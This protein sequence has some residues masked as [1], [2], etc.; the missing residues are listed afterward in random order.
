MYGFIHTNLRRCLGEVITLLV[1]RDPGKKDSKFIVHKE[2]LCAASPFF[3]AACKLEW[4]RVEKDIIRLPEDD[5]EVIKAFIHW[6]Y[7]NGDI[8]LPLESRDRRNPIDRPEGL[9]VKLYI[10]GDKYQMPRLRNQA[11][12]ALDRYHEANLVGFSLKVLDYA[13][14]NAAKHSALRTFLAVTAIATWDWDQFDEL[15]EKLYPEF[16]H[17]VAIHLMRSRDEGLP[18]RVRESFCE[19]YHTH[20][21]NYN[22]ADCDEQNHYGMKGWM[23]YEM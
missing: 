23:L 18:S 21:V 19:R 6:I 5:P 16:I 7:F 20:E 17:D 9:L 10:L 22:R 1:G 3:E 14:K 12:D 8:Q 4:Q 15:N 11:V 2:I 13:S